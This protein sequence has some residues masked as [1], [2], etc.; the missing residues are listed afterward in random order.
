[1]IFVDSLV[2][3]EWKSVIVHTIWTVAYVSALGRHCQ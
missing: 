2:E 3:W 1:L